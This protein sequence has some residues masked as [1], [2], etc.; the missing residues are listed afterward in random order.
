M[1]S[2]PAH[3]SFRRR[4][5]HTVKALPLLA[6]FLLFAVPSAQTQT[7]TVLY[8]FTG[9]ADG[10]YPEA[11]V[12]RDKAGT[13]YSTTWFGGSFNYGTVFQIDAH[14]KKTVLHGFWGGDG[15]GPEA[16]LI[17]D[18][19]GTLYGTTYRGGTPEGGGCQYGCGTVFK[20]DTT[21]RLSVLHA[22]TGGR[23]GG[24]PEFGLV[25]DEAGSLYGTTTVGGDLSCSTMGFPGC[26]VVFKVDINGKETV[27]HAFT[28]ADG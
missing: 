18:N 2:M 4:R 19:A 6:I 23:D 12:L 8:T 25:R 15:L 28:G 3:C 21:G 22:F 11:R 5:Q 13:L 27:L 7:F 14:G 24:Q 1:I 16:D 9:K 10:K 20:L 17:R 26:G